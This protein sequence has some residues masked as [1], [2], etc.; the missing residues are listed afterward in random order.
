M[1]RG[2]FA[3]AVAILMTASAVRADTVTITSGV[4]DLDFDSGATTAVLLGTNTDIF[5]TGTNPV[6]IAFNAG[7]IGAIKPGGS[8]DVA[9]GGTAPASPQRIN[10]VSFPATDR[11]QGSLSLTTSPFHADVQSGSLAF[12]RVPFSM[13]G[14]AS[15]FDPVGTLLGTT[16][17]NGVGDA[18]ILARTTPGVTTQY[19]VQHISYQFATAASPT[20]TPEPASIALLGLALG[21][22]WFGRRFLKSRV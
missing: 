9:A 15:M 19:T 2:L 3:A 5:A 8:L 7:E 6:S 18:S 1:K 16:S 4:L 11:L 17:L 22:G 20:P 13:T 10:G 21:G 14:S 12:F